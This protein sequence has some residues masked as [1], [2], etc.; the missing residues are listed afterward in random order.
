MDGEKQ[1]NGR[2]H[3]ESDELGLRIAAVIPG[4]KEGN[5]AQQ[6][7]YQ[8]LDKCL[9]MREMYCF[10]EASTVH[11]R[12]E[13]DQLESEEGE[14][15]S[16]EG[17][18]GRHLLAPYPGEQGG[19][20]ERLD[21]CH[22]HSDCLCKR[23]KPGDVKEFE[24]LLHD[25]AGPDRVHQLEHACNEVDQSQQDRAEPSYAFVKTFHKVNPSICQQLP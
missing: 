16:D 21:Q 6:T 17:G 10:A 13:D 5:D 7:E 15:R 22:G 14:C 20:Q 4:R 24:I 1:D 2:D 18:D 25:Q 11:F 12:I 19:A 3:E 8:V 23:R 9:H